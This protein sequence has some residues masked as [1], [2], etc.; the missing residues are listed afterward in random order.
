MHTLVRKG[1]KLTSDQM[2][3]VWQWLV[4]RFIRQKQFS[5]MNKPEDR[6]ILT[7]ISICQ[8]PIDIPN[9]KL[10]TY[11]QQYSMNQLGSPS[12]SQDCQILDQFEFLSTVKTIQKFLIIQQITSKNTVGKMQK[13]ISYKP[14]HIDRHG[15]TK[16]FPFT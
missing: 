1:R 16:V 14:L 15:N 5:D 4:D 2:K 6:N 12:V 7:G 11:M 3:D 10:V 9:S 8:L 13:S